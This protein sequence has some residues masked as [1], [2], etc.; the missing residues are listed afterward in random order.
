MRVARVLFVAFVAWTVAALFLDYADPLEVVAIYV[1][2]SGYLLAFTTNCVFYMGFR[3]SWLYSVDWA[4]D[5]ALGYLILA[6]F[7]VLS[8]V[9]AFSDAHMLLL[10]NSEFVQVINAMSFNSE[11]LQVMNRKK[12][13]TVTVQAPETTHVTAPVARARSRSLLGVDKEPEPEP[14]LEPDSINALRGSHAIRERIA[15]TRSGA[16]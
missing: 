5:A 7:F 10:Y 2:T 13:E 9:R 3:P 11:V 8:M 6:P 4:H 14:E 16:E 12:Q 15:T 1:A